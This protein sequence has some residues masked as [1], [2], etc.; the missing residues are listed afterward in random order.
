[1][2]NHQSNKDGYELIEK[3]GYMTNLMESQNGDGTM[4]ENDG[5]GDIGGNGR[6]DE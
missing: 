1:L 3:D 2:N 4:D 5:G 6:V